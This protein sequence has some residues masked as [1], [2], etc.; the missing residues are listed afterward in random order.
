[1][2]IKQAVVG[3]GNATKL[4]VMDMTKRLLHLQNTPRPDDAAD[5]LALAAKYNETGAV[6]TS[7]KKKKDTLSPGKLYSLSKL[8]NVLSK[9]YK[10]S[11][12]DSLEIVQKLTVDLRHHRT[13][14]GVQLGLLSGI[15]VDERIIHPLGILQS[16]EMVGIQL[17]IGLTV[18]V[19][20]YVDNK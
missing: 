16:L 14:N 3:Y 20:N 9:R 12:S 5:A 13:D 15:A 1:M 17:N 6:V 11:M 10:M 19:F 18:A 7:V 8:Q 4:Q 2:Q